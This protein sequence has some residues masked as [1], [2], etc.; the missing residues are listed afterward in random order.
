MIPSSVA[1]IGID[2][3]IARVCMCE[4]HMFVTY[5]RYV[6][7][8]V[9]VYNVPWPGGSDAKKTFLWT[10]YVRL[11]FSAAHLGQQPKPHSLLA[12]ESAPF[13]SRVFL[14]NN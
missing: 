5:A 4:Y 9:C 8:F 10:K 12:H 2:H 7:T 11:L 6:S 1:I 3:A 14:C 13:Q